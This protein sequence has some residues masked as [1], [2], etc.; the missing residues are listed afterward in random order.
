MRVEHAHVAMFVRAIGHGLHW[1]AM[2][3]STSLMVPK[4]ELSRLAGLNQAFNGALSIVAPTLGAFLLIIVPLHGTMIFDVATAVLAISPLLVLHVPQ[5]QR[6]TV[7]SGEGKG[8]VSYLRGSTVR[9]WQDVREGMRLIWEWPELRRLA[10]IAALLNFLFSPAFALLPLL[11]T[12]DFDGQAF[13][14]GW[15]ESAVGAGIAVSGLVLSVWGGFRR[16]ILTSLMGILVMGAGVLLVGMTPERLLWLALVGMFLT[17]LMNS[18][19]S[20]CQRCRDASSP[21]YRWPHLAWLLPVPSLTL[22]AS[23][24]GTS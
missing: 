7:A 12:R 3:A 16:R 23:A 19:P 20:W 17:G 5:P 9:L 13:E 6:R 22:S 21:R 14:I 15:M 8:D 24:S 18:M 4:E 1:P 10:I 11:V 2:Q